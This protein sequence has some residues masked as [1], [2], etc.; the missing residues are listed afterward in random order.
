MIENTIFLGDK[1]S[2]T[3]GEMPK[4]EKFLTTYSIVQTL[5]L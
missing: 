5:Q 3:T 2:G 1:G 4:K